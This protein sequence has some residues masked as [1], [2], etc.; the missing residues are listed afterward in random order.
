MFRV[1]FSLHVR[2]KSGWATFCKEAKLP[3]APFVGLD[4]LDDSVGQ[5][6]LSHVAWHS[7]SQMFLCQSKHDEKG[8]TIRQVCSLLRSAKWVEDREAR[9]IVDELKELD[10]LI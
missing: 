7:A 3:F 8:K 10:K 5:F 6:T 2:Y 9:Q 4:I 1:E